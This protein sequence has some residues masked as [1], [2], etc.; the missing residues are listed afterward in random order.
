MQDFDGLGAMVP[1]CTVGGGHPVVLRVDLRRLRSERHRDAQQGKRRTA[2]S[3]TPVSFG[4]TRHRHRHR[5][6]HRCRDR[7]RDRD[8]QSRRQHAQQP[9]RQRLSSEGTCESVETNPSSPNRRSTL[10]CPFCAAMC[11]PVHPVP[12]AAAPISAPMSWSKRTAA[13][14]P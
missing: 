14:C 1:G 6:R 8:R 5:H 10:T 13:A 11:A 4:N 2:R 7:D 3:Q 9:A 12:R